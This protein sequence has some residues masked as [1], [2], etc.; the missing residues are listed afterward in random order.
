MPEADAVSEAQRILAEAEKRKVD[1]RLIGG[2]AF[3]IRSPSSLAANLKRRYVDIDLVGLRS[4]SREIKQLLRDLGY[5][6]RERFNQMN[7]KVRLIF[8]DLANERRVDIFLN[9]FEMCHKLDFTDR[10]RIEKLTLPLA[11]L[12]MTKL[13]VYEI[14]EREYKDVIA[15]LTDNE[16]GNHDGPN[17]INSKHISKLCGD[18][19]GLYKTS[20]LN[21]D[22]I[23]KGLGGYSLPERQMEHVKSNIESLRRAIEA[24]P[25]S[26][27]W[28]A[29]ARVGEKVKW[30]QLPEPDKEVVDSR[31]FSTDAS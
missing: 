27:R 24:A 6:P 25:K 3:R 20:M 21:L 1:V 22:R 26:I 5:A 16:A 29:R 30:Y 13:Q 28:R 19:W 4:Q 8:N 15:L 14:T 18:D 23:E 2:I 10:I 9:E 31:A 12:L 11:D 17:T 7:G